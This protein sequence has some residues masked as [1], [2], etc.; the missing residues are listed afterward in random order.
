MSVSDIIIMFFPS[1]QDDSL[2]KIEDEYKTDLEKERSLKTNFT[3][4]HPRIYNTPIV[5]RVGSWAYSNG[6]FYLLLLFM[7]LL[8]FTMIKFPFLSLPFTGDHS[9]KYSTYVEP[10]LYM[11]QKNDLLWYQKKYAADPV[12]NPEGILHKFSNLPLF[13]WGLVLTYKVIPF[14]TIEFKSRLFTHVIGI[15]ILIFAYIFLKK[16]LPK[17]LALLTVFLMAINPVIS[18]STYVTVLDSL[19]ILC[20]FI[21]LTVLN[22]YFENRKIEFLFWAGIVFG[23]GNSIKYP[24]LLWLSPISFFLIY[25]RKKNNINL[26]RDYL[27]YNFLGVLVIITNNTTVGILIQSPKKAMIFFILW[28]LFYIIIYILLKKREMMLNNYI[29]KIYMHRK[30]QVPILFLAVISIVIT[31]KYMNIDKL[32]EEFL[33]DYS[34]IFNYR[35]YKY[36]LFNQFKVYMTRNIFWIGMA[37][38]IILIVSKQL[39]TKKIIFSFL[40]GSLVYWVIAAKSIFFHNYY[41]IIIMITFSL[42]A[43]FGIYYLISNLSSY[44]VKII[45]LLFFFI[46]IFSPAHDETISK[47]GRHDN[48]SDIIKYIQDKTGEKDIIINEGWLSPLVIYTGRAFIQPATLLNDKIR[49]EIKTFGFSETMR[50]YHIKYLFSENENP[51]YNDFAPFFSNTKI[52]EP[53]GSTYNR[54]IYIYKTI[55]EKNPEIDKNLREIE[56][57]VIQYRIPEKFKLETVIGKYKFYSFIN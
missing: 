54:S 17:K 13:E 10:A 56:D 34:L 55:G 22:N 53:S 24:L 43:S 25:Y 18:F 47:I 20:M 57:V 49:E 32:S 1:N 28:I 3:N 51:Y 23:I 45:T 16:W 39:E 9:M 12:T 48:I 11:S 37:G 36:M 15:F 6:L 8:L 2:N 26:I 19:A 4:L 30:M 27:I 42:L 35:L 33:T 31:L 14:G 21:S 5:G 50:K 7:I 44:R 29:E 40:A 52:T 38:L 46:L 41:T